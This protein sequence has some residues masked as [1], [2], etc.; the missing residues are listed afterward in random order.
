MAMRAGLAAMELLTSSEFA[1]LERLGDRVRQGID[2]AYRQAGIP[3]GTTGLG[4]LIRLHVTSSRVQD[5]R[6]AFAGPEERAR[7]DTLFKA[8]LARGVL[9]APNGLMALST[10]MTET[11]ADKIVSAVTQALSEIR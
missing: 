8:L 9:M 11:E 5:Y 4:S 1:R 7:M 10:P 2:G 6:S 3:G